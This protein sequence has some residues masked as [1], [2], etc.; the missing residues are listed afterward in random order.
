MVS[1]KTLGTVVD[2]VHSSKMLSKAFSSV[3]DSWRHCPSTTN[4][5]P[6]KEGLDATLKMFWELESLGIMDEEKSSLEDINK[7]HLLKGSTRNDKLFSSSVTSP[8][9]SESNQYAAIPG[10]GLKPRAVAYLPLATSSMHAG[11]DVAMLLQ[12]ARMRAYNP[13]KPQ[14][15]VE[16]RVILDGG[17]QRSYVTHQIRDALSL[18]AERRQS[19]SIKHLDQNERK[20]K[21]ATLEVVTWLLHCLRQH[22]SVLNE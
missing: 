19:V 2:T 13:D 10:L 15:T 16:V 6:A 11:G 17:S 3:P 12:M 5:P 18:R 4:H 7:Q 14:S 1:G 9:P 21:S 20:C 8:S 22:P